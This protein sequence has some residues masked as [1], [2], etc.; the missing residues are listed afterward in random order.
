MQP[1]GTSK[2]AGTGMPSAGSTMPFAPFS[3]PT[4]HDLTVNQ[5]GLE[6]QE[7]DH[8]KVK[9]TMSDLDDH[10]IAVRKRFVFGEVSK[11]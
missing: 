4:I 8:K 5:N 10:F 2:A 7:D 3:S 9:K 1:H 11:F 6:I